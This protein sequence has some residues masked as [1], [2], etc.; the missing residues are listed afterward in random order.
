[1]GFFETLGG[2]KPKAKRGAGTS[3]EPKVKKERK[4][5]VQVLTECPK[6]T[7]AYLRKQDY[8]AITSYAAAREA[9]AELV[10]YAKKGVRISWDVEVDTVD[11]ERKMLCA[12]ACPKPGTSYV[13]V[14]DHPENPA[15]WKERRLIRKIVH[16]LLTQATH[17][18][19]FHHGT[20]D[21]EELR[22]LENIEVKGYDFDTEY[23]EYIADPSKYAYGLKSIANRN[24]TNFKGYENVLW[25]EAVPEG[26]TVKEGKKGQEFHLAKVPLQKFVLYNGADCDV[27]KRVELGTKDNI[28]VPLMRV[29]RDAA[30]VL[31]EMEEFGPLLDPKQTAKMELVYPVRKE[32]L[33]KQLQ[34]I[35][36]MK[37]LNPNSPIQVK[38]ILYAKKREGGFA[39]VPPKEDEFSTD[40]QTLELLRVAYDHPFISTLE[41]YRQV[42]NWIERTEAFKRSALVHKGRIKTIWWLTGTRTG[43]LSSGGGQ[44]NDKRN[45]GNLQNIPGNDHVKN[46][47]VS[48]LRWRKFLWTTDFGK[49]VLRI[50]TP[51]VLQRYQSLEVFAAL[52]YSQME[53]RIL[54]QVTGERSMIDLFNSGV[55]IHAAIGS[56][57]SGWSFKQIQED[58]KLR[59]TVKAFHFGIIYGLTVQGLWLD[60]KAKGVKIAYSKV[61]QLHW[62]YFNRFKKVRQYIK[63]MPAFARRHGYVENLF[64]FRVPIDVREGRDSGSFWAN[65]AVNAPIQ[66][67]AH[68][69]MLCAVAMIHRER[70]KYKILRPQMEIHDAFM[71]ISRLGDLREV[72]RVSENLMQGE[73]MAMTKKEFGINWLLPLVVELKIGLRFGGMVRP[74]KIEGEYD[75]VTAF[76]EI[77]EK[78]KKQ[79]LEL[80]KLYRKYSEAA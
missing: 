14:L 42:K 1:M 12:G 31:E 21:I 73:V 52:D 27:T 65:Q 32:Y 64:G 43:R 80:H 26:M 76:T 20:S 7:L 68:H 79:D 55:D 53:L 9:A 61:E 33:K 74:K 2:V 34:K 39:F 18:K 40:K 49:P 66:G 10:R 46:M 54:A 45:L 4:A 69:V 72:A 35:S 57:W 77:G 50:I 23:A 67:A 47:L 8:R 17:K 13:F 44:R 3:T 19:T 25:P 58:D 29:Y 38:H 60:L 37:D 56:L 59:R 11:G 78:A 30:F 28:S 22:D 16:W 48:D 6:D 63:D 41:E 62:A 75:L 70:E 5:K 51:E 36:G 71:M 24:L 15:S